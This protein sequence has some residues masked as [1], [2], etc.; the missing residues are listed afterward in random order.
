M[1]NR[2]RNVIDPMDRALDNPTV[3]S[4]DDIELN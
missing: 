3:D 1:K 4:L 2:P